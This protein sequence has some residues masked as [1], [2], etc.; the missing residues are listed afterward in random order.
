MNR[1]ILKEPHKPVIDHILEP[2]DVVFHTE[3]D[4]E[5]KDHVVFD[6]TA[7]VHVHGEDRLVSHSFSGRFSKLREIKA[8]IEDGGYSAHFP[9]RGWWWGPTTDREAVNRR[10]EELK[11]YFQM[12]FKYA[13]LSTIRN[14]LHTDEEFLAVLETFREQATA[15]GAY[16]RDMLIYI[17]S[18]PYWKAQTFWETEP[19]LRYS[20]PMVFKLS[21][22]HIVYVKHDITYFVIEKKG[23]WDGTENKF[24]LCTRSL[25]KK[26]LLFWLSKNSG[27]FQTS[28]FYLSMPLKGKPTKVLELERH[29][30]HVPS[31]KMMTKQI[32]AVQL[33]SGWPN[34][35]LKQEGHVIM[36]SVYGKCTITAAPTLF[37]AWEF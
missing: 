36:K 7:K 9:S 35:C 18:V 23:F 30:F 27:F 5:G 13:A 34:V 28:L 6:I 10:S 19:I 12:V 37:S 32:P 20:E 11:S 1:L 25:K 21:S 15:R 31:V 29:T 2:V 22:S 33:V 17:K 3:Q 4:E 14:S 16:D 26:R 24:T 8:A